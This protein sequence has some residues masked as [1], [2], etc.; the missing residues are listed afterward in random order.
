MK[1]RFN[2]QANNIWVSQW[3]R[4]AELTVTQL[5]LLSLALT[6]LCSCSYLRP[7]IPPPVAGNL[8]PEKI[9][10]LEGY[11]GYI[12]QNLP[13]KNIQWEAVFQ[14]ETIR[15]MARLG[16]Y[17]YVATDANRLH[18]INAR[19]GSREWQVQLPAPIDYFI[20]TVGDLPKKESD[21]KKLI[22]NMQTEIAAESK[23]QDADEEKLKLL[24]RQYSSDK[25][26]FVSLVTKDVI[27]LTSRGFI[28][29]LDRAS[30][31]ILWENRLAFAPATTP[32][33][34]IASIYIGA[35]DF[36]RVYQIDATLKYEQGFFKSEEPLSNTPL[37]DNLV[38]YFA[39]QDGAI[40]AYDTVQGK[41][42]WS[43]K[44]EKGI[45][46]DLILD[47]DILYAGST[48]YAVYAID[49]YS[50]VLLWQFGAAGAISTMALDKF[51]AGTPKTL[52]LNCDKIGLYAL[53]VVTITTVIK[54]PD[55]P[56]KDR[57]RITR[58]GVPRWL[59]KQGKS[60]LLN[61]PINAYIMGQDNQTLY[62]VLNKPAEQNNQGVANSANAGALAPPEPTILHQYDLSAFSLEY[63]DIEENT[64]YLATPDGYL[65]SV[66][67]P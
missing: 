46:A 23:R 48:D 57:E 17:V 52:Y 56:D 4:F 24:N 34:S 67:E 35:M 38:I 6:G 12:R 13:F 65:F 5:L 39:S 25:D 30:G 15:K 44:T 62:S 49:R 26:E 18:S 59:F 3:F 10:T 27:Y 21:L 29:C 47:E 64:L 22:A 61:N 58:Q 9:K 11:R 16:D 43:Y 51:P 32:V 66:K 50:G 2:N 28:Y 55:N 53:D 37:Y 33:A 8:T 45:K 19:T 14:G 7:S 54:D 42:L 1:S 41:L 63:G 40:Y 20:C 31:N 60:F 36:Y